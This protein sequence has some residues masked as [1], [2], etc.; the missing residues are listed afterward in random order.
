MKSLQDMSGHASGE[1]GNGDDRKRQDGV[2]KKR[3]KTPIALESLKVSTLNRAM[4]SAGETDLS[5]QT[6]ARG[7][8]QRGQRPFPFPTPSTHNNSFNEMSRKHRKTTSKPSEEATHNSASGSPSVFRRG[9]TAFTTG[10]FTRLLLGRV[11]NTLGQ[12]MILDEPAGTV[13]DNEQGTSQSND[14]R[15]AGAAPGPSGGEGSSTLSKESKISTVVPKPGGTVIENDEIRS[16]V[17]YTVLDDDK[18]TQ[19]IPN[20]IQKVG[21][22]ISTIKSIPGLLDTAA[23]AITQI[24]VINTTFLQPLTVF[25]TVADGLANI[26]PYAQ[27]ALTLLTTASDMILSQ[28]NLDTSIGDLMLRIGKIYELILENKFTINVMRGVLI[29][30]AQVVH[31]CAQFISRYSE[32]KNFWLRLGKNAFSEMSTMVTKYNAKLD[33]LM[34]ELRDRV[35]LNIQDGIHHIRD[36]IHHIREDVNLNFLACATGILTEIVDWIN[37]TDTATPR[38]FWLYGQAGRGKSAIA[39]TIALQAEII[40]NLGS[41]FCFTRVRQHEALHTKLFPTV[42]RDLADHNLRLRLR[43][44]EVI[45]NNHALRGT[46]DISQQWQKFILEPLSRLRGSLAGN[47]VIVI[48]ALDESGTEASHEDVLDILAA[49]GADLPANIRILLT[50]RPL[51]DIK[52]AL[53]AKQHILARSSD[54][55]DAESTA[56]DIHL[57]I[58]TKLKMHGRTFSDNDFQQLAVKSGGTFEWARL[59]C[60]FIRPQIG[61]APKERFNRIVSHTSDGDN[62][63]DE[64]YTT[65]LK[66]VVQGLP[67]VLERFRSVMWQILWSKEP[68]SISALDSMHARFHRK[69][70][71]YSVG[72]ILDFMASLLAGTSDTFTPVRP[73]HASFYDFLLDERR[74]GEFFIDPADVH[75]DLAITS[76]HVMEDGLQFNICGLESSYVLNSEV[77]DGEGEHSNGS[78]VFVTILGHPP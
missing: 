29:Q 15:V 56:R 58:T 55:V 5:V 68:L 36:D 65:F 12:V 40:G 62:L 20:D 45:T 47:I 44:A 41:C 60:D 16:A 30:I 57:Y 8:A 35:V 33:M 52:G 78:I 66:H 19:T 71:C 24:N 76:F 63:L 28:A 69:D 18:H 23:N 54:S 48:D 21:E 11:S 39:R 7:D 67:D 49:Q 64:L 1:G 26:H 53:D 14:P 70:D 38:I 2:T 72:I 46:E 50:S 25:S 3:R 42:A 73:L 17:T 10:S 32:T 22:K 37:A 43:L 4:V 9:K 61:V 6:G 34:Q 75:Y 74:S 13:T 27:L 31:E 77:P 51:V 59:A